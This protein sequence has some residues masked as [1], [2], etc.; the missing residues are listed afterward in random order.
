MGSE[1]EGK[2]FQLPELREKLNTRLTLS[3]QEFEQVSHGFLPKSMDDKWFIY[4]EDKIL[5]IHRSW[6][7]FCIF[8]VKFEKIGMR[9]ETQEVWV[10]RDRN[11]YQSNGL[12]EDIAL[13]RNV[14]EWTFSIN[15]DDSNSPLESNARLVVDRIRQLS[16][17]GELELQQA[18]IRENHMGA[19]IVDGVLQSGLNYQNV[20]L[21]RV[22]KIK[23]IPEARTVSGFLSLM[24]S[25][26]L[27][28][29]LAGKDN[30]PFGGDKPLTIILL[31][32]LLQLEGVE[33]VSDFQNW[34]LNQDNEGKLKRIR[35]IGDKTVDYLK[36]LVGIDTVAVDVHLRNFL[37]KSGGTDTDYTSV[38]EIFL[39]ASN[40][41]EI[42]PATL[43]SAVWQYMNRKRNSK[44]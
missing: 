31:A 23:S 29:L 24:V 10:T 4:M 18:L 42:S 20:V 21:P 38:K 40:M 17:Q 15:M 12:Q 6:T 16:H 36:L 2:L 1:W 9:Y 43:D 3:D 30:K 22:E 41:L 33:T 5:Y 25:N 44:R 11:Q 13:L 14:F 26:A 27:D 19:V 32:S 39:R 7:G 37:I 28:Q 35:R 34:L 8:T